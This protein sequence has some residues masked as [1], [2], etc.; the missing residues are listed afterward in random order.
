VAEFVLGKRRILEIYLNVVEWGLDILWCR[1]G[2][3]LLRRNRGSEYRPATGG[4]A[5]RD[6]ASSPEATARA[7]ERLQRAHP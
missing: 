1:V 3:S 4:M 2:V 5:R 6:S 7:H